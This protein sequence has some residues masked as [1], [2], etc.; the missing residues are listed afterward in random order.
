M[1]AL[2][3]AL[4]LALPID[5]P[6]DWRED[7][8]LRTAV[9]DL[10]VSLEILDV[11]ERYWVGARAETFA[12]DLQLLR[13]RVAAL[14]DAPPLADHFRFPERSTCNDQCAFNRTYR[15]HLAIR[16]QG[17]P[18]RFLSLQE[19]LCETDELYTVWDAVRDT[20]C[21]YY[22][23]SCRRGALQ[24]L[25]Q[26]LGPEAYHAGRLPAPVPLHRFQRIP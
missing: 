3:A 2:L 8:E 25:R 11:W 5:P 14:W 16:Q 6:A 19:A 12:S 15:L 13:Q 9:A 1:S 7:A 22:Y 20:K 23:V 4:L 21:E 10:A 17:E 24:R 18:G 26:L